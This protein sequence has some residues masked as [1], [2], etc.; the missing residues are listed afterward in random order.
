MFLFHE[1]SQQYDPYR[2][3]K[4]IAE[5]TQ[6]TWDTTW[7][8]PSTLERTLQQL[9][10]HELIA[11]LHPT[12][13]IAPTLTTI[14]YKHLH[15]H[16]TLN[17]PL[18]YQRHPG[19]WHSLYPLHTHIGATT[20]PVSSFTQNKLTLVHATSTR[21]RIAP[22]I[23]PSSV[24]A[25]IEAFKLH[26]PPIRIAILSSPAEAV[27]IVKLATTLPHPQV[28]AQT[29]FTLPAHTT[30]IETYSMG[31]AYNS[32]HHHNTTNPT[33]LALTLI[34]SADAPPY[35]MTGLLH[36]LHNIN[37]KQSDNKPVFPN[38]HPRP[39]PDDHPHMPFLIPGP[40]P[41]PARPTKPT[42]SSAAPPKYYPEDLLHTLATIMGEPPGKHIS[43][44]LK[45]T[46]Q[47]TNNQDEEA[48]RLKRILHTLKDA[49]LKAHA[50]LFTWHCNAKYGT[51][52]VTPK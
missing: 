20:G 38:S 4:A 39:H 7:P 1:A 22:T 12:T 13:V 36:D 30:T 23:I 37:G 32:H 16:C 31:E 10:S 18:W 41:E 21:G 47:H 26:P 28:N 19:P 40:R 3:Y 14:I 46:G 48:K 9:L 17:K 35:D 24:K 6:E 45:Q 27:A 5:T 49:T 25:C 51:Q 2:L 15:T 29:I 44:F 8:P 33:P 34:D 50:R 52:V 43:R 11:P 42:P